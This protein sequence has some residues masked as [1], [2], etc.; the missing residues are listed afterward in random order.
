MKCN[1]E[2]GLKKEELAA[3]RLVMRKMQ[4]FREELTRSI[5]QW[6]FKRC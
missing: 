1:T 4:W 3:E 6:L 5:G 2:G